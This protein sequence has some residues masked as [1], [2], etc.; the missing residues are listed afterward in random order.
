M[1]AIICNIVSIFIVIRIAGSRLSGVILNHADSFATQLI[2][3]QENL[4][5]LNR[6]TI[7][8]SIQYNG[9]MRI[10]G[11]IFVYG[12]GIRRESGHVI[13]IKESLI[14]VHIDIPAALINNELGCHTLLIE[15]YV[16][17]LFHVPISIDCYP[18]H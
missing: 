13:Y 11:L 4:N 2:T 9:P 10:Y 6:R 12:S 18:C 7:I 14:L 17:Q 16:E 8:I 15:I 3:N 5:L 1:R